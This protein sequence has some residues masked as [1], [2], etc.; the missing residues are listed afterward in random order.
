[1]CLWKTIVNK[2]IYLHVLFILMETF[3]TSILKHLEPQVAS[4]YFPWSALMAL[5]CAAGKKKIAGQETQNR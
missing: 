1:M 5:A 4:V 3:D 2:H